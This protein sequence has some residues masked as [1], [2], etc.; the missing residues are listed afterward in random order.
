MVQREFKGA[1]YML[2][3]YEII[4]WDFVKVYGY[5]S[6]QLDYILHSCRKSDFRKA[7]NKI[8]MMKS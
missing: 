6:A 1:K 7:L 4:R 5:K 3:C 2:I 8:S